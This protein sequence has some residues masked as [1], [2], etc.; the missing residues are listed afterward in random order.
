MGTLAAKV[1]AA[2]P[3]SPV[4]V[5]VLRASVAVILLS[6][7]GLLLFVIDLRLQTTNLLTWI[8]ANP[9]S[10]FFV[11]VLGYAVATVLLL[12]GLV[13]SLGA[14]AVFGLQL[15]L[16]AVWAGATLG[17][18]LA[19]LLGRFLFRDLVA[20]FTRRYDWWQALELAIESEGWKIVLL[21]RLTPLVPF[22]LLNY[23]LGCTAVSFWQY[24]WSSSVG[25]LPGMAFFIYLGSLAHN[26][27]D[28]RSNQPRLN[29]TTAIVGIAV[30]GVMITLL[31]AL[32]GMY[33]KRAVALRLQQQEK[34]G[35][36]DI[37]LGS[38]SDDRDRERARER[39]ML[40][41]YAIGTS[42]RQLV[43]S[44]RASDD[45]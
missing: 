36:G 4:A 19:F 30:S 28:L 23:A 31:S 27:M 10:G 12:P 34:N 35:G 39:E 22:N 44:P 13:L 1:R 21:L 5:T 37:E 41:P 2:S 20:H 25:V 29:S 24:T 6:A 38:P 7:L 8:Q 9:S 3:Q 32:T 26:L 16:L 45:H 14:G 18:T 43:H 17:E 33:A 11:F 15:G 42:Q 40:V